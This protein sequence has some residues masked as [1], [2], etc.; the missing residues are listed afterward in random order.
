[1]AMK[2]IKLLLIR[3]VSI[4]PQSRFITTEKLKP[5]IIMDFGGV[6][7]EDETLQKKGDVGL[8][9]DDIVTMEDAVNRRTIKFSPSMVNRING[10]SQF[11]EIRWLSPMYDNIKNELE[12]SVNI[13]KFTSLPMVKTFGGKE[14]W[15]GKVDKEKSL[16]PFFQDPEHCPPERPIL[17]IDSEAKYYYS[18]NAMRMNGKHLRNK[19]QEAKEAD[20]N[21]TTAETEKNKNFQNLDPSLMDFFYPISELKEGEISLKYIYAR[22]NTFF[23]SPWNGLLPSH[24]DVVEKILRN[25]EIELNAN[26]SKRLFEW[27]E[28]TAISIESK[29]QSKIVVRMKAAGLLTLLGVG[30]WIWFGL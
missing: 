16:L 26:G 1:M 20:P 29:R 11:A 10:W 7:C 14:Q 18:W 27:Y 30:G 6:I 4:I 5:L 13:N 17:W 25:P 12:V 28:N 24:C 15:I 23:L 8:Q 9:W 19:M 21:K 2:T 3:R 22:P